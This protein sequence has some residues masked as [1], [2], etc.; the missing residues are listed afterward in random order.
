MDKGIQVLGIWWVLA[1]ILSFGLLI[2]ARQ[3]PLFVAST[4]LFVPSFLMFFKMHRSG[5]GIPERRLMFKVYLISVILHVLARIA[6]V[7]LSMQAHGM[8]DSLDGSSIAQM[9]ATEARNVIVMNMG[10]LFFVETPFR[11]YFMFIFD[12]YYRIGLSE[13]NK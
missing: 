3:R 13:S 2:D 5:Y 8:L 12:K 1:W 4:L 11:I 7:F 10:L 9:K 6:A